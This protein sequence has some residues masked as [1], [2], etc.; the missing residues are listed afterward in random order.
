MSW[1]VQRLLMSTPRIKENPDFESDEYNDLLI[2]EKTIANLD[3]LGRLTPTEKQI[4]SLVAD[5]YLLKDISLALRISRETI[6]KIFTN[7]CEKIAFSIGGDLT[8]FGFLEK[9]ANDY[10]LSVADIDT[11]TDYMRSNLK[12]KLVK[13]PYKP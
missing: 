1:V 6:S 7:T 13:E 11:V 9:L 12:H 10:N 8:D 3:S 5:G 4:L 2:I